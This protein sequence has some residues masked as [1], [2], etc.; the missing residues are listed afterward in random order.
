MKLR[1][2]LCIGAAIAGLASGG[3]QAATIV[4]VDR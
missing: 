3:A 1:H 4:L 2:F